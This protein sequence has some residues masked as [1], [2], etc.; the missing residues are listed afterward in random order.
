M[1]LP[2]LSRSF[3]PRFT[4]IARMHWHNSLFSADCNASN[5]CCN[6]R[7]I[8]AGYRTLR[9]TRSCA[10]DSLFPKISGDCVFV[11]L[12]TCVCECVCVCVCV[13]EIEYECACEC[14]CQRVCVC[15][16]VNMCACARVY[17]LALARVCVHVCRVCTRTCAGTQ[18]S[19]FGF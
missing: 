16:C 5:S 11:H 15:V 18:A 7:A 3:S 13:R 17:A 14:V 10:E 8:H 6:T 9:T 19:V 2:P 12:R 1:C 4:L